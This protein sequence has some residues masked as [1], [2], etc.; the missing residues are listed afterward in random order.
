MNFGQWAK[1]QEAAGLAEVH[2]IT[3]LQHAETGD[4]PWRL[5]VYGADGYHSGGKWFRKGPMKYP[6]EEIS[7]EEAYQSVV[8]AVILKREVRICDGGDEL[9]FHAKDGE[10]VYR[11][12][13][14]TDLGFDLRKMASQSDKIEL[15]KQGLSRDGLCIS[16]REPAL[17]KCY[18]EAGRREYSISGMCEKC[19]DEMFGED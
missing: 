10:V 19:F 17:P 7:K 18:S 13:F 16:C 6:D 5:Y 3:E 12:G 15:S 2:T 9:V 14:W 8:A 11:A 1:Q 4:G